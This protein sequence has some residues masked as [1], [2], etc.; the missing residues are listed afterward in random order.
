MSDQEQLADD[1]ETKILQTGHTLSE[2][3]RIAAHQTLAAIVNRPESA[4][5][6]Q[7]ADLAYAFACLEGARRG[8]M[9]STP[10]P[11]NKS[12]PAGPL[13]DILAAE[14]PR[15]PTSPPQPGTSLPPL[16][17]TTRTNR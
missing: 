6:S 7:L 10:P 8:V 9:P 12:A 11:P 4:W 14:P 5:T 17:D 16:G 13:N 3:V 15:R 1:F 2:I